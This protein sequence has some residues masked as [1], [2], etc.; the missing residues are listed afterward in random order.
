[1]RPCRPHA[2]AWRGRADVHAQDYFRCNEFPNNL[3][4]DVWMPQ[5]AHLGTTGGPAVVLGKASLHGHHCLLEKDAIRQVSAYLSVH[6]GY[7]RVSKSWSPGT[8]ISSA[9]VLLLQH[10]NSP[11]SAV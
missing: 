2:W 7:R 3:P 9:Y 4:K 5:W 6:V 11:I 10:V 8:C 1:M